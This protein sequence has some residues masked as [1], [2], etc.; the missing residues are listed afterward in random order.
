[1]SGP[2]F[3]ARVAS[4][5]LTHGGTSASSLVTHT[6]RHFV[7][8]GVRLASS[9]PL[10]LALRLS[11]LRALFPPTAVPAPLRT[12]GSGTSS[13]LFQPRP[14]AKDLERALVACITTCQLSSSSAA[15]VTASASSGS[16]TRRAACQRDFH[17]V[18]QR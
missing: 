10:L 1:V 5:L 4:S 16:G 8:A 17:V 12:S 14:F 13:S 3:S 11:L 2:S 7:D 9:R 6:A 18:L 15:G